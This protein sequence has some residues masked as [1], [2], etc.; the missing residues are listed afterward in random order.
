MKY[1]KL[2]MITVLGVCL[3][4]AA[5]GLV[6]YVRD[7]LVSVGWQ[8][9]DVLFLCFLFGIPGVVLSYM[10]QLCLQEVERIKERDK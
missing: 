9:P 10:S 1:R 6:V 5:F 2:A 4:G 8:V 3:I 7:Y